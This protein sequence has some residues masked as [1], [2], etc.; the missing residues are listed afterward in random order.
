[1]KTENMENVEDTTM[2]KL[3]EQA[4]LMAASDVVASGDREPEDVS[5]ET[6]EV[7]RFE[8]KLSKEYSFFDGVDT[9]KISELDLS[10]LMD[11]NTLDGEMLDR[12]MIKLNHKPQ[13]KFMDTTYIKHVAVKVTGYPVEFFNML[14]MKD[15]QRIQGRIAYF[16][17]YE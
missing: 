10:G 11:L 14:S 3:V 2:E 15:I 7:N 8:V 4:E 16:F 17:L 9:K 12:I 6:E 13:N 1:M 5:E